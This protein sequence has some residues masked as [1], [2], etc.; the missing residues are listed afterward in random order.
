MTFGLC[1]SSLEGSPCSFFF[2]DE[3][4][5]CL[6]LKFLTR[7]SILLVAGLTDYEVRDL[8]DEINKLLREKGH[9]ETQIINLGGANYRRIGSSTFD[10][11]GRS[12]PGQR[13]YKYFGRAKE[14][15][16]VKELFE[17]ASK[18]QVELDSLKRND[19]AYPMFKNQGPSYFGDLDEY[20]PD[21]QD[22]LNYESLREKEGTKNQALVH[23]ALYD[24]FPGFFFFFFIGRT[25]TDSDQRS[26]L[27]SS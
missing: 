15:P 20:G 5:Y 18:Q 23:L 26:V 19:D 9:W 6:I 3:L 21:G 12:V 7:L 14:L 10:G 11:A 22:L 4:I 8:N 24:P 13:G 25:V 2:L 17:G 1:S 27:L 16:G